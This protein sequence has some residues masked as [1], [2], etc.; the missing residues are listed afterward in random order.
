[1]LDFDDAMY[2]SVTQRTET[3][4]VLELVPDGSHFE[5]SGAH[6]YTCFLPLV[7]GGEL[8]SNYVQIRP[9]S[10]LMQDSF[11]KVY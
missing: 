4:L 2:R 7:E 8:E 1:M 5:S 11:H 10:K 9:I 3:E 6:N